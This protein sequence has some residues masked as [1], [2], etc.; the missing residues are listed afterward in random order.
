MSNNYFLVKYK[1]ENGERQTLIT[2]E[3]CFIQIKDLCEELKQEFKRRGV[4][5]LVFA[6][7]QIDERQFRYFKKVKGYYATGE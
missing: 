2:K 3:N 5:Y 7:E 6:I 1:D 4:E